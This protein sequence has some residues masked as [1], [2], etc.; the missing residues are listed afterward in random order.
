MPMKKSTKE[1]V[2]TAVVLIVRPMLP[3]RRSA[4][5]SVEQMSSIVPALLAAR[6]THCEDGTRAHC[7]TASSE[8]RRRLSTSVAYWQENEG[9]RIFLVN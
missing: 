3:H 4:L 8:V 1:I 7:A 5:T 9:R 6:L 2:V